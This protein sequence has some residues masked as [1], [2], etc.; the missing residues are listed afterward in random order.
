MLALAR[1][2]PTFLSIMT[3]VWSSIQ[4]AAP[5]LV[6]TKSV[7]Y[8]LQILCTCRSFY[9]LSERASIQ[10]FQIYSK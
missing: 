4:D 6:L 5:T 3:F 8:H 1:N 9:F 10:A 2:V 7:L